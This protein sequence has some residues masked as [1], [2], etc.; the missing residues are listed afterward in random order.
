MLSKLVFN[1]LA[2]HA[3][4]LRHGTPL[5]F[6][7][8]SPIGLTSASWRSCCGYISAKRAAS[9]PPIEWPTR[10]TLVVSSL[11]WASSASVL[12]ASWPNE[13]W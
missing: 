11:R 13:Y 4:T 10:S 7:S 6:Q 1:S 8:S 5:A 12:A 3:S 9:M 2:Y